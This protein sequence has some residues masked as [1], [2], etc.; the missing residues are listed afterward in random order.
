MG[1]GEHEPIFCR[2]F[3]SIPSTHRAWI[4]DAG[5]YT[6]AYSLC[7]LFMDVLSKFVQTLLEPDDVA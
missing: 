6:L 2:V 4:R 7:C 5:S 1:L 3:S